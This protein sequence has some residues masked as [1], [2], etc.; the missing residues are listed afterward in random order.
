LELP[1]NGQTNYGWILLNARIW[2]NQNAAHGEV[3][4]LD[5]AYQ[6]TPGAGILAG[7]TSDATPEPSTLALF[8]LGAV[9]VAA[10]RRRRAKSA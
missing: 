2:S 4:V 5:Y 6:S 1:V 10:V 3:E 9:G 8:A 7:Q